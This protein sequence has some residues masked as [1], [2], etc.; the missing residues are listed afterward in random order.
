MI[1]Y[2]SR[3]KFPR[4]AFSATAPKIAKEILGDDYSLEVI[5]ATPAHIKELNSKYRGKETPTDILSFPLNEKSGEIYI[6]PTETMKEARK[7]SRTY[8]N[9]V[10]FLFIHGCVHLKGYDHGAKMESTEEIYRKKFGI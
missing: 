9:F 6:C 8:E 4:V 7:F 2:L 10:M 1:T 5:I 3:A